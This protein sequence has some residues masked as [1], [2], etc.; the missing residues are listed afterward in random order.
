MTTLADW[1]QRTVEEK[2]ALDGN[3]ER[4]DT[5]VHSETFEDFLPFDVRELM[6]V[7]LHVMKQYSAILALRIAKF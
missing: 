5:F 1:Q 3:I 6:I 7:Q 4:L 2:Q